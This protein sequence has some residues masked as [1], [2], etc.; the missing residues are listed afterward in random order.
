MG[1]IKHEWNG[2]VLTITS[3][4]GTSSCDLK[5]EKGDDGIRGA[6]GA[7]GAPYKPVKGIDYFTDGDIDKSL[8]VEGS[9]ADAKAVGEALAAKADIRTVEAELAAKA[10]LTALEAKADKT[11]LTLELANKVDNTTLTTELAKKAPSGYGLGG[12]ASKVVSS[13]TELDTITD[14]GW[15]GFSCMGTNIMGIIFNF[16]SVFVS[17]YGNFSF[18]ELRIANRTCVLYR[19]YNGT[20]WFDWEIDNPPM[21]LGKEYRT[22]ERFND[23]PVYRK[24]VSYTNTE[25]LGDSNSSK[26][27]TIPHGISN[28]KKTVSCSASRDTYHLLP[29]P[30]TAGGDTGV[31]V[32]NTAAI[33]LRITKDSWGAGTWYF[34]LKYTKN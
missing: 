7:T 3:D 9:A 28:L 29:Y 26:D 19:Y 10:D 4:S 5:G 2:T 24:I 14:N 1:E 33:N 22:T 21:A 16:A 25:T 31:T 27:I 8:S 32:V 6:Q 34:D 11:T 15:Y 17:R 13:L 23:E 20:T 12:N 30:T 18:Q